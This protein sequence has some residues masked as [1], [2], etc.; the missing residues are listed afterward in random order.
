MRKADEQQSSLDTQMERLKIDK[1]EDSQTNADEDA[2]LEEA[3][4]LAAAEK[5]QLDAAS[6][7]KEGQLEVCLHGYVETKEVVYFV[8]LFSKT[9][10]YGSREEASLKA[11]LNSATDAV[12]EKY[13]NVWND[14]SKLKLVVSYFLC[15]GTHHVLQG[16]FI[17]ARYY[18]AMASY[19]QIFVAFKSGEKVN[20][21]STTT[22]II[23]IFNCDEHTLVKYVRKRIPCTCLDEVYKEV[24]SITRTGIC[25]NC[26]CTP[27]RSKMLTCGR[28]GE[29]NYCSRACQKSDW[30]K[31]KESCA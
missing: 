31:H 27:E 9:F 11:G 18:A 1:D 15:N 25:F 3:I 16:D 20:P 21:E 26:S 24:K 30:P 28:C 8:N 6:A 14:P 23:E 5:D 2:L 7:E 12:K 22:K 13:P 29:A 4:K 17:R 19:I 10:D